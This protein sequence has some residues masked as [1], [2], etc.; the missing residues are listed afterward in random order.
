MNGRG[1][2]GHLLR[3]EI[4]LVGVL[5]VLW[6]R[7]RWGDRRALEREVRLERRWREVCTRG[8]LGLGEEVKVL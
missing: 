2:G 6:K 7:S 1:S 4:F 3:V 5:V 8:D